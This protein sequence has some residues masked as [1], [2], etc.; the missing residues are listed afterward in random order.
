MRASIYHMYPNSLEEYIA[1]YVDGVLFFEGDDDHILYWQWIEL[2]EKVPFKNIK[3]YELD[4]GL[5][6]EFPKL[7]DSIYFR[8][9]E[10]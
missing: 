6:I 9:T 5:E 10:F 7:E 2:G 1:V 3:Q 8:V 4:S